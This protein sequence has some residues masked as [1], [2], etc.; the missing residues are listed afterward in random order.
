MLLTWK[1]RLNHLTCRYVLFFYRNQLILLLEHPLQTNTAFLK[2]IYA[3]L[4]AR[5][6]QEFSGQS[7][8]HTSWQELQSAY[9]EACTA[10]AAAR[11]QKKA[12]L[13]FD[14]LGIYRLFFL[15]K[16]AVLL[17]KMRDE[18]LLLLENYDKDHHAHLLDTLR[19]YL[20]HNSSLQQTAA[21][22]FTHRNTVNYR[23]NKIK[24]LTGSDFTDSAVRF[25]YLLSFYIDD[26]LQLH[27]PPAGKI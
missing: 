1:R 27:E 11:C 4:P 23:M 3:H 26:Y 20:F 17:K 21:L 9:N 6:F 18:Q 13:A 12:I 22:T 7:S 8:C 10:A 15:A 19:A 16:D 24:E 2:D 5:T 25:H 14:E